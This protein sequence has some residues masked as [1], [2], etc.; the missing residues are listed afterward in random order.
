MCPLLH[1]AR[2][3]ILLFFLF[4]FSFFFPFFF[5]ERL[6]FFLEDSLLAKSNTLLGRGLHFFQSISIDLMNPMAALTTEE[7]SNWD[8]LKKAVLSSEGDLYLQANQQFFDL[9]KRQMRLLFSMEKSYTSLLLES[10][11]TSTQCR[12]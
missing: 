10:Q 1:G 2:K 12:A 8:K 5:E 11:E 9:A 4:F 7:Q 6:Y 3:K